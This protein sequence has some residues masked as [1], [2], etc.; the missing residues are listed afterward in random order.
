VFGARFELQA[1]QTGLT[2]P[3]NFGTSAGFPTGL[4]RITF[5]GDTSQFEAVGSFMLTP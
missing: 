2:P 3:T 4:W 5:R 1:D